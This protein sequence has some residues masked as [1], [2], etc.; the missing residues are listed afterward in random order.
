M[1]VQTVQYNAGRC[2]MSYQQ[3]QN[4]SSKAFTSAGSMIWV[5]LPLWKRGQGGIQP[6]APNKEIWWHA[7]RPGR[8]LSQQHW[9]F[10]AKALT[11]AMSRGS[12]ARYFVVGRCL[13]PRS[14]ELQTRSTRSLW[15]QQVFKYDDVTLEC[16]TKQVVMGCG[17]GC[18]ML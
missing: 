13:G 16:E 18:C 14:T 4:S 10:V 3:P 17:A 12:G 7:T 1:A 8:H 6:E 2:R 9:V 11:L 15:L 5:G